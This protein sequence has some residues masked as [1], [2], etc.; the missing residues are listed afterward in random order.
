[1]L[2]I[3]NYSKYSEIL[4]VLVDLF[5]TF[6]HVLLLLYTWYLVYDTAIVHAAVQ[7]L[8]ISAAVY[9]EYEVYAHRLDYFMRRKDH[10]PDHNI[11]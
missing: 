11:L 3:L 4:L 5:Q 1:M 8:I 9:K 7:L 6:I 10:D 2:A